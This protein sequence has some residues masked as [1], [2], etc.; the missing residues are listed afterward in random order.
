M[1]ASE[2]HGLG[3]GPPSP[4]SINS[5]HGFLPSVHCNE[6]LPESNGV[7][8]K[9]FGPDLGRLGRNIRHKLLC[10]FL[11]KE[12]TIDNSLANQALGM[13]K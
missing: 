4:V 2:P 7:A 10:G 3:P 11:Q 6:V 9:R 5:D 8:R 12:G 13:K 1:F